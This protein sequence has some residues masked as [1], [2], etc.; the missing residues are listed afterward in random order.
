MLLLFGLS[1]L[2][3]VAVTREPFAK[4]MACQNPAIIALPPSHYGHRSPCLSIFIAQLLFPIRLE[5]VLYY[6]FYISRRSHLKGIVFWVLLHGLQRGLSCFTGVHMRERC[7]KTVTA[8]AI[9]HSLYAG[10]FKK[11]SWPDTDFL[12]NEYAQPI[13]GQN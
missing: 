9:C 6:S 12:G 7:D 4:G 1:E 5:P 13:P 3:G 8:L 10:Y 2:E 11:I